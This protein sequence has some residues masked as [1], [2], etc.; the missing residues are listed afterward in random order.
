[1]SSNRCLGL[2]KTKKSCRNKVAKDTYCHFHLH[3]RKQ[4]IERLVNKPVSTP[5]EQL[6]IYDRCCSICLSDVELTE[7]VQL[8]CGHFHH[9]SCLE[10]VIK[11]ECPVC[12]GPLVFKN[13]NSFN[14]DKI[15]ERQQ[16]EKEIQ[17]V[18]Q[19]IE[20]EKLAREFVQ[21]PTDPLLEKIL[22]ES[23][24]SLEHD[25]YNFIAKVVEQSYLDSIEYEN[26][27]L[28]SVLHES[29]ELEKMKLES[30]TIYDTIT[31]ICQGQSSIIV[32]LK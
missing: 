2:T 19:L 9:K 21:S 11:P 27:I 13:T 10:G 29:E 7:D 4:L 1:M 28:E 6:T 18:E 25:D 23:L 15:K 14:M 30:E 16:D 22:D 12:R 20:D 31:R 24:R 17:K 3:Q 8:R 32:T 5:T 26:A